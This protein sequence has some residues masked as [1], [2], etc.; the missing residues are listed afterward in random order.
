MSA[1]LGSVPGV[2]SGVAGA[3]V[4]SF[5]RLAVGEG[6]KADRGLFRAEI[7]L[8]AVA[9]TGQLYVTLALDDA[10]AILTVRDS[11]AGIHPDHLPHVFERFYRSEQAAGQVRGLGLGLSISSRIIDDLLRMGIDGIFSDHVDVLMDR[12]GAVS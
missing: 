5:Q 2:V 4:V 1:H 3:E 11:G 9:P 8:P 6:I 7:E 12:V 10:V